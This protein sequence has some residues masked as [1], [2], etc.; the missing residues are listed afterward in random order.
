MAQVPNWEFPAK[1]ATH[2]FVALCPPDSTVISAG[3][4]Q[5]FNKYRAVES[6]RTEILTI[7]CI[8]FLTVHW[9]VLYSILRLY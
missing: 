5:D 2:T 6:P 9:H 3:F 8:F 7:F 1:Y 4:P